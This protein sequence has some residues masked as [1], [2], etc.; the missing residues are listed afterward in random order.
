ML[1]GI[2]RENTGKTNAKKLRKEGYL[3]ANLYGPEH[4]ENIAGAF[5]KNDF[6]RFVKNKDTFAFD[7]K[8]GNDTYNV[9]IGE[10]QKNP[11]TY[12]LKHVDLIITSSKKQYYMLPI[13][14]KGDAIGVKNKGLLV[15]HRKRLKIRA[16]ISDL[17]SYLEIDVTN[18]DVGDNVLIK[19]I[20]LKNTEI[21]LNPTIPLV[22]VIKAK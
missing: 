18:L 11:V 3:I 19:D 2:L 6:I 9:V 13:R 7:V 5:K 10:Y 21:F 14:T 15:S 8:I 1:E 16:L 20:N 17:P 12:D 4:K 22:G